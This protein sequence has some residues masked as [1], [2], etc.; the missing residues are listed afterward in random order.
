MASKNGSSLRK[1]KN[2]AKIALFL[3]GDLF[4]NRV[5]LPQDELHDNRYTQ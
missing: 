5:N 4:K 2:R 1:A 3:G